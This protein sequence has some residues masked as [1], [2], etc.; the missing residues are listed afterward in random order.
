MKSGSGS[1]RLVEGIGDWMMARGRSR[2]IFK[3]ISKLLT[4]RFTWTNSGGSGKT[5]RFAP[6]GRFRIETS[7]VE[8]EEREDCF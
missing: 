1:P 2:R 3:G 7:D 5:C 8:F 4:G 6:L